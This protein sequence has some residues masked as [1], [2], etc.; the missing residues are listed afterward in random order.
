MTREQ[1]AYLEQAL[2]IRDPCVVQYGKWLRDIG[3]GQFG[4]SLLRGDSVNQFVLRRGPI[5]LEIALLATVLSWIVGF[6]VGIVSAVKLNSFTDH[7]SRTLTTTQ[8]REPHSKTEESSSPGELHPQALTDPDVNLSIHPALI[9]QPSVAS[10]FANGQIDWVLF[11]QCALTS[12]LPSV[13]G[14]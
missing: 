12:R 1:R 11:S 4:K 2:G 14:A 13:R 3:T 9:A 6:P 10:P 7:A 8:W 5:T